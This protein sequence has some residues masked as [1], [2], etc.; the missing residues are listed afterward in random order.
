VDQSLVEEREDGND[1]E[2]DRGFGDRDR[3]RGFGDRD[4]DRDRDRRGTR[5][6]SI[7]FR[8]VEVEVKDNNIEKAMRAL[9]NR[10]SKEGVLQELKRRR[11]YEKP[12]VRRKRK[13]RE[14]LKRLRRA[15]RRSIR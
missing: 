12:S 6:R 14:A 4:R 3:D 5:D 10:M 2:E 1:F 11:F 8:A 7:Y 13:E 9:K 15:A